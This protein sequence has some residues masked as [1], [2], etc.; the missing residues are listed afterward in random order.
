MRQT[1]P[2]W[3]FRGRSHEK[4]KEKVPGP[5]SYSPTMT[6]FE[7]CPAVKIG[8]GNRLNGK[9]RFSHPGPGEYSPDKIAWKPALTV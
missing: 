3:S 8:S 2:A 9:I 5:G 7:A 4:I 6:N 1:A